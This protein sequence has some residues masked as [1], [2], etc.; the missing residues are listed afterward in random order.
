MRQCPICG[1]MVA[2]C[3]CPRCGYGKDVKADKVK[4]VT[5]AKLGR[6]KKECYEKGDDFTAD[7]G[8][9]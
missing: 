8:E 1:Y 6:V 5:K 7:G 2:R 3:P 4:G 9:N